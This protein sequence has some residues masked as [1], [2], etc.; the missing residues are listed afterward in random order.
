[1]QQRGDYADEVKELF[2]DVQMPIKASVNVAD[3][4]S[5]PDFLK[6]SL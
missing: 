5:R 4:E 6:Q 1:M 2:K 3:A